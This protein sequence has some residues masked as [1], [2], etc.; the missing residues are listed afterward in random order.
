MKEYYFV[1]LLFFSIPVIIYIVFRSALSRYLRVRFKIGKSRMKKATKGKKNYWWYAQLAK[2]YNF[3]FLYFTNKLFTILF[4]IGFILHLLFGWIKIVS[5]PVTLLF[6]SVVILTII[7]IAFSYTQEL[8]T[9]FGTWKIIL[10]RNKNKRVESILWIPLLVYWVIMM[11]YAQ[12]NMFLQ[13]W[14]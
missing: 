8:I 3:R 7:M 6:L 13:L 2:R 12:C 4:P 11:E 10:R 9:E 5:V 14:I 1:T